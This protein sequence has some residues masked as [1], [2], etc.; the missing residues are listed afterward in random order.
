M[1]EPA[2]FLISHRGEVKVADLG[3]MKQLVQTKPGQL[4][5][6]N[7]FVGTASYMSPERIDGKEY[8]FPSDIWAFGLSLMTLAMGRLPIDTQG[9]YWSILH[10]IRDAAPP[11]LPDTFSP[12]FRDFIDVCLKKKPEE[13]AS[14]NQLLKHKFL[15]KAVP[16]DLTYDQSYDR[17]KKE[18]LS[19]IQAVISHVTQL[20]TDYRDKYSSEMDYKSQCGVGHER[21]FGNLY[22]DSMSTI[23]RRV[24]LQEDDKAVPSANDRL[25]RRK[26]R[27]ATLSRQ[28][29]IQMD[30]ALVEVKEFIH[31]LQ[32]QEQS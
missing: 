22:A 18:L 12:E 3:I 9:G 5:R 20:R 16:D 21:V 2:N 19:I 25:R 15:N 7:T 8:S 11:S 17:G 14:C 13:R 26:P 23:L 4:P 30:R 6:T 31:S 29:H 24:I 32:Q 1:C 10:G 28:L 27:L